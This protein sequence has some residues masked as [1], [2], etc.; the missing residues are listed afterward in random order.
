MNPRQQLQQKL[1]EKSMKDENFRKQ[2]IENPSA[3]IESETSIKIQESIKIKVLEEDNNSFYIIL[4]AQNNE[5]EDELTDSEL[6]HVAGGYTGDTTCF[7]D[8]WNTCNN[9]ICK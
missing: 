2:L 8:S 4:P 1:I 5:T 6:E 7:A 3:T 9:Y